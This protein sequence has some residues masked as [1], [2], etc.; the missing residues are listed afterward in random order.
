MRAPDRPDA[1]ASW[2]VMAPG[3]MLAAATLAAY[4]PALSAGYIWDDDLYL[5]NNPTLTNLAGLGRIWFQPGALVQYYPLVFTSFWFE[6]HLWGL[7]PFGYHAV[8]I[9]LHALNAVLVW[10]ILKR[11]VVPGAWLAAAVFALHPVHVESVA[12]VTERKNVLSA[13]LYLAALLVYLRF[14]APA[15]EAASPKTAARLPRW[16]FY[17]AA[18]GLYAGALLSKTVTCSLPAVLLL[19]LWWKRGRVRWGDTLRLLPF[20]A[21]G[22]AMA[23]LTASIEQ[24]HVVLQGGEEW[25]LS[26][27]ERLLVAGRALWFYAGKLLWPHPLIF[28]YPRW[29]LDAESPAQWLFPTAA[30]AVIGLLW[31]ARRRIGRTPLMAALCFGGTL[32]PALGFFNVFPFRY[33]FVADHFQ[34]LA[35]IGL[36]ALAAATA[37]KGLE[38]LAAGVRTV[39]GG[40]TVIMLV[41]LALLTWRQSRVYQDEETLWRDTLA[42]HPASWM[43]HNNLGTLLIGQRKFEEATLHFEE[44]LRLKPGY[45]EALS[46]LGLVDYKQGRL[47]EAG[48][49]FSEALARHPNFAVAH[50][51][52]GT[53]FNQQGR[54]D[55]AVAQYTE[56]LRLNAYLVDARNNLGVVFGKQGRLDEAIA[57]FRETL[58]QRPDYAEGHYN[59]GFALERQGQITEAAAHYREALRL[60]PDYHDARL[61]LDR[62]LAGATP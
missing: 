41:A 10:R 49:K 14:A 5:T 55:E 50:A 54:L 1:R 52:L 13:A 18:M 56:A 22:L 62:A 29:T 34:Y 12:W 57:Q 37:S 35:S 39:A 42:K 33:A 24:R 19:L 2:R 58:R 47:E 16:R 46:N 25:T 48:T 20:F 28:N 38:R 36:I 60:K 15:R 40:L 9:A 21:A 43:A 53:V 17:L 11:L 26:F 8:N 27:P 7:H 45:V 31:A 30:L 61:M 44:T 59:L 6:Y 3:L 51:N 23:L 4:W 32:M